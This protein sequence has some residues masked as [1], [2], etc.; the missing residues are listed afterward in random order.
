MNTFRKNTLNMRKLIPSLAVLAVLIT[1]CSKSNLQKPTSDQ[2]LV[3]T[4]FG[5]VPASLVHYVEP[6]NED[7]V[8]NGRVT[9]VNSKTRAI[10]EDYGAFDPTIKMTP[11][12]ARK[13]EPTPKETPSG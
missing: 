4:P 3:M 10:V 12:H 9:K 5:R 11:L 2:G 7:T 8:V 6:G 13:F 1:G